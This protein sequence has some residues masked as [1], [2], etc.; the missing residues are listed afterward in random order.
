MV[1][2]LGFAAKVRAVHE[3][4]DVAGLPHAFGGA[5]A[6]AYAVLDPRNTSDVDVN[7][8]V[9][10]ELSDDVLAALPPGLEI[11]DERR[12][13][14]ARD[15]QVRL[16]WG[17]TP[18]DIFLST[19]AFHFDA[20]RNAVVVPLGEIDIPVLSAFHLTV[21]KTLFARPKDFL[22]IASMVE[23]NS[24]DVAAARATVATLLGN[25]ASELNDFDAAVDDGRN[26]DRDEPRNRFPRS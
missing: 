20:A 10:P 15:G 24:F 5:I 17:A 22:D 1:N 26:P 3:A 25:E 23:A 21:F 13:L 14:L 9:A 8:F 11:T 19:D 16:R 7:V 2:E 18:I 6:L 12:A 4:L